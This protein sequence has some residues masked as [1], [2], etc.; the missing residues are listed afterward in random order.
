MEWRVDQGFVDSRLNRWRRSFAESQKEGSLRR[1]LLTFLGICV[2]I[3]RKLIESLFVETLTMKF[4]MSFERH[5]V[6]FVEIS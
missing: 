3:Q 1:G 2:R 5:G 6:D 4:C